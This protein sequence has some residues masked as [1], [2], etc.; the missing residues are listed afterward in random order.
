M[1]SQAACEFAERPATRLSH[2]CLPCKALLVPRTVRPAASYRVSATCLRRRLERW[3]SIRPTKSP[4]DAR[5]LHA[6]A[7]F[8]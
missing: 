1:S 6:D 5:A 4:T 2:F 3:W 7:P 8:S